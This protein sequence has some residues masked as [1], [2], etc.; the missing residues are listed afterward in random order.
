MF[1][2]IFLIFAISVETTV[3]ANRDYVPGLVKLF[4]SAEKTIDITMFFL[5][6]IILTIRRESIGSSM[7]PYS[8]QQKEVFW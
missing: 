8:G 7:N 1:N 5:L 2:I 6:V 4:D 3:L